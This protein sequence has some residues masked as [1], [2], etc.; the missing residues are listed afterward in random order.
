ML[1]NVLKSGRAVEISIRIIDVFVKLRETVLNN[2]DLLLKFEQLDKKLIGKGHDI[3]MHNG[4]I[5][6]IFSLID[7]WRKERE[8]EKAKEK[9]RL[10]APKNPIG[11]KIKS[12]KK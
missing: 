10:A 12:F 5:E 9:A 4:E 3:K 6:T 1:A 11:F 7:E 2:E 8:E